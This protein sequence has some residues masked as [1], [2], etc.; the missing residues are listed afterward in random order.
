[1]MNTQTSGSKSD[2]SRRPA[3]GYSKART[4][5]I[6]VTENA[7]GAD[8]EHRDQ[9]CRNLPSM[10]AMAPSGLAARW[11]LTLAGRMER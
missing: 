4:P 5:T 7:H 11:N 8:A 1:M 6:D 2:G 10:D 3:M 9:R